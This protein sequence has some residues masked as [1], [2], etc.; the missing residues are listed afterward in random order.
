MHSL[1]ELLLYGTVL[2]VTDGRPCWKAE[3][4]P[5]SLWRCHP[6]QIDCGGCKKIR[7]LSQIDCGGLK[8]FATTI[9]LMKHKRYL[10]CNVESVMVVDNIF[11][12]DL[13]TSNYFF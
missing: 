1:L 11:L 2:S 10:S 7:H 12:S 9:T 8:K 6:S 3:K 13:Y 4:L 5:Y